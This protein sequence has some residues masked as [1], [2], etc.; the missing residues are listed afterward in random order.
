MAVKEASQTT[1]ELANR[2]LAFLR[3]G[4]AHFEDVLLRFRQAPYREIL[5][6]WGRL[7][8]DGSLGREV[9]TGKYLL[10]DSEEK[11]REGGS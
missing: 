6:A 8:K 9:E 2:I 1:K 10:R 7:R 3:Q 5:Q 4:P 11:G